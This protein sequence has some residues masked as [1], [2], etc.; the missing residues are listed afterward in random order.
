[1]P[2]SFL[3]AARSWIDSTINKSYSVLEQAPVRCACVQ[4]FL[5]SLEGLEV[6]LLA[7]RFVGS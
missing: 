1:M 7:V 5:Q 6:L 4:K 3:G 2:G